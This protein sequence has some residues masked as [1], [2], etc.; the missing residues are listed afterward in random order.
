[1]EETKRDGATAGSPAKEKPAA[2]KKSAPE[3]AGQAYHGPEGI[4][5][6]TTPVAWAGA[7]AQLAGGG[8]AALSYALAVWGLHGCPGSGPVRELMDDAITAAAQAVYD[9][10]AMLESSDASVRCDDEGEAREAWR[11]LV[12]AY[13]AGRRGEAVRDGGRHE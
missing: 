12:R 10:N 2:G 8:F 9:V 1:M 13:C 5:V 6:L 7:A 4:P 3:G 11:E